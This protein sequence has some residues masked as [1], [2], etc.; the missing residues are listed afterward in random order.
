M[1][2]R[3]EQ[4]FTNPPCSG[5]PVFTDVSTIEPDKNHRVITVTELTDQS[6]ITNELEV[7]SCPN[8]TT[9]TGLTDFKFDTVGGPTAQ[10]VK[11]S[12][13]LRN[14]FRKYFLKK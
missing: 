7:G 5:E 3:G 8:L 4:L 14:A 11:E 12:K 6:N 1:S 13:K 10:T 2:A 9:G